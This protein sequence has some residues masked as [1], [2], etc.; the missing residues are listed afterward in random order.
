MLP[1]L[2][3]LLL[4]DL[5]VMAHS[6]RENKVALVG[7]LG[8]LEGAGRTLCLLLV[9]LQCISRLCLC[10]AQMLLYDLISI[11]LLLLLLLLLLL[12][13]GKSAATLSV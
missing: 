12:R 8:A 4:P 10:I 13:W 7:N 6:L 9:S 5:P 2:S 1:D 3:G 11:C